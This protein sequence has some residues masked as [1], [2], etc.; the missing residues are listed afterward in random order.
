MKKYLYMIA[1]AI[2]LMVAVAA[3]SNGGGSS[4]TTACTA[5]A[6]GCV[7][8]AQYGWLSQGTCPAGYLQITGTAGTTGYPYT[9]GYGTTPYASP[10]GS[11]YG[12]SAYGN[13]I[14]AS[15]V[16]GGYNTGYGYT[17]GYPYN[18]G[19]CPAGQALINGQCAL[20]NNGLISTPYYNYPMYGGGYSYGYTGGGC[21][22]FW[23]GLGWVCS[24]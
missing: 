10:Y 19:Y 21:R 8:S 1:G 11:A 17:G 4:S 13:C 24:Y 16:Q 2:G 18:Q 22:T 3:C 7:Y 6:A 5:N 20:V 12:G 14:P 15:Q 23:G 9:T